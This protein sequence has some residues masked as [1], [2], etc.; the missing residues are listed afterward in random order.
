MIQ[1]IYDTHY[2]GNC[3]LTYFWQPNQ[4][5]KSN[6]NF[7]IFGLLASLFDVFINTHILTS[8]DSILKISNWFY[9]V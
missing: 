3:V 7:E 8:F 5:S 1:N 4:S 2:H 9:K 6:R